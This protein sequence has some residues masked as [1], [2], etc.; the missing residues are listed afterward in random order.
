MVLYP[1]IYV[2]C[3]LPLAAGRMASMTG[4]TVT[5]W[6]Y[7]LAGAA[8][9]SCGWLDVLLYACTRRALVFSDKPPSL[10]DMGLDTFGVLTS[11]DS[12]Y[13]MTTT[14]EGGAAPRPVR[15]HRPDGTLSTLHTGRRTPCTSPT[16]DSLFA[17][18][19]MGMITTKTT[20]EISSRS[21]T[22]NEASMMQARE[23]GSPGFPGSRSTRMNSTPYLSTP[24]TS[25]R[26]SRSLAQNPSQSSAGSSGY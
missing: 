15:G 25:R 19:V 26:G 22:E 11:S 7:C 18:P 24:N 5:Y 17:S 21:I 6:Y 12:W 4:V 13:G 9:A 23:I 8:I 20:I 16:Q 2:I 1:T 3:T 14:I 10:D